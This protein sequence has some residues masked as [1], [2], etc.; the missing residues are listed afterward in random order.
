M[1]NPIKFALNWIS[2]N[3]RKDASKMLIWTGVIGWSISSLAQIGAVFVNPKLNREQK[4][5]LIPQE[6]A[7][8]AVNIA[9]FF[10]VTQAA[11]KTVSKLFSTGKF[12][13]ASVRNYLNRNKDLY[14]KKIGKLDFNLDAVLKNDAN[15]PTTEYYA[16]KNFGT[17]LATVSAGILS[18]NIITPIIRNNMASNMQKKYLNKSLKTNDEYPQYRQPTFKSSGMR[19]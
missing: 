4:S 19:I 2:E 18:S 7:D 14:A 11:K 5:F 9:S 1:A 3:F 8:A 10:L 12:A 13:P 15:F 6:F 17:M 16:C